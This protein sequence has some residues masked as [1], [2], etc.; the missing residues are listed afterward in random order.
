MKKVK[1]NKSAKAS[2]VSYNSRTKKDLVHEIGLLKKKINKQKKETSVSAARELNLLYETG[3]LLSSTLNIRQIYLMTLRT[4][5][6]VMDCDELFI[7]SF[8]ADSNLIRYEFLMDK[9]G[10]ENIDV[11]AIPAIPLAPEGYG[12]Q[13]QAIRSRQ[14]IIMNDYQ[15]Q[16]KRVVTSYSITSKGQIAENEESTDHFRPNSAMVIPLKIENNVLGV[17]Q[18][19]SG[20]KNAY[21]QIKLKFAESLIHLVALAYNNALLFLDAEK[22]ISIRKETEEN[23]KKIVKEKEDLIKEVY[24]RVKNNLQVVSS[25]LKL[26]SCYMHDPAKTDYLR[27]SQS[28]IRAISLVHEKLFIKAEDGKL[29]F[30][31][32]IRQLVSDIFTMFGISDDRIIIDYKFY[33][34]FLDVNAAVPCG[35]L[36]NELV[37]NSINHAFPDN[38]Q[39]SIFIEFNKENE[40]YTLKVNDNGPG[41]SKGLDIYSVKSMG[42]QL[43]IMLAEQ[44]KGDLDI[45]NDNGFNF[46]LKFPP[47]STSH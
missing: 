47:Y 18:I 10:K 29:D 14:S 41:I 28:R 4:L 37:T 36:V 16:F 42:M 40:F 45:K 2:D 12:I 21:N 1:R 44:L 9:R 11:T 24:Y 23:L 6:K 27:T 20:K 35:L 7:S 25:L 30:E 19:F 32:Y 22:E 13:S 39:G 46:S 43:V 3:K 38:K 5:S 8:N 31:Q 33:I 34:Q 15:Q 17:V 26:Q